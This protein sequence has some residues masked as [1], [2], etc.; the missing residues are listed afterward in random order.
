MLT[1]GNQFAYGQQQFAQPLT[2]SQFHSPMSQSGQQFAPNPQATQ[3]VQQFQ[4]VLSQLEQT[5]SRHAQL[6]QQIQQ[7]E[8]HAAHQL[9]QLRSLA[10]QLI[11]LSQPSFQSH[12]QP[13]GTFTTTFP[14]V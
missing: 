12:S 6:L 14:R 7:D 2:P 11:Q 1:Q 5:E 10:D 8:Q 13:V 9:R 4:Q 3:V